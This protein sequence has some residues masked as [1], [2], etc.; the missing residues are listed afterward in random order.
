[1]TREELEVFSL[2]IA[3]NSYPGHAG[4]TYQWWCQQ[5]PNEFMDMLMAAAPLN[6]KRVVEIG[7]AHGG[8]L[9]FYD[10]LVGEGGTVVGV[11][12][13]LTAFSAIHP[14]YSKYQSRGTIHR[15]YGMSQDVVEEVRAKLDY[16][17]ID[18]LFIDGDHSYEAVKRDFELYSPLVRPGGLVGFHDVVMEPET[19]RAYNDIV[20]T[21][22][23]EMIPV[24]YM[25]IGLI[26]M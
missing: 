11:D 24:R 22:R 5:Q 9:P 3:D 10:Q 2:Q 6:P 15:V 21:G 20:T 1:M 4:M 7:C 26:W 18:L 19:G 23:K 25:G 13:E 17:P 12:P 16:Q 14:Q 8:C